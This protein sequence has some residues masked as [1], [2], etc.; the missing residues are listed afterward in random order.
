MKKSVAFAIVV[1]AAVLATGIVHAEESANTSRPNVILILSDA[2]TIPLLPFI[3][4]GVSS[5]S[6]LTRLPGALSL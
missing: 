5:G 1:L 3:N 6:Q 4:G 2:K